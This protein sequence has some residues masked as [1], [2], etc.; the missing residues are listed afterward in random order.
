MQDAGDKKQDG[1]YGLSHREAALWVVGF[2]RSLT[3]LFADS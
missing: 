1:G 3:R 2:A